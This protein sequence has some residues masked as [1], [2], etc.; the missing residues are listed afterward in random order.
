MDSQCGRKL[1]HAV[2]NVDSRNE[3]GTIGQSRVEALTRSPTPELE[4]DARLS[5]A[6][7]IG[8]EPRDRGRVA[9]LRR[10]ANVI[11]D[12]ELARAPHCDLRPPG[13]READELR[14]AAGELVDLQ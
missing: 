2:R 6:H 10:L 7:G 5:A 3:R 13:R 11:G 14:L 12:R 9:A 1:G 8:S 4:D